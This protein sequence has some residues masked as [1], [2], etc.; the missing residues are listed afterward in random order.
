MCVNQIEISQECY[1]EV[2]GVRE[3]NDLDSQSE[4]EI[5][6]NKLKSKLKLKAPTV[7]TDFYQ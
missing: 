7:E 3:I 1:N 5:T 6:R 4:S 2:T